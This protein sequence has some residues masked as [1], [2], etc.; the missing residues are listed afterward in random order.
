[1]V[2]QNHA[3]VERARG[4]SDSNQRQPFVSSL[5]ATRVGSAGEEAACGCG[6]TPHMPRAQIQPIMDSRVI[7]LT[8]V[9]SERISMPSPRGL[10][11]CGV[12][13]CTSMPQGVSPTVLG[14]TMEILSTPRAT[15]AVDVDRHKFMPAIHDQLRHAPPHGA[16]LTVAGVRPRAIP[17]R[18][19]LWR[20]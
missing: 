2:Q 16:G 13:M 15:S 5:Y 11:H 17:P 9:R 7:A 1:M 12:N 3:P 6:G 20:R 10:F 14:L 19:A 18:G 8:K 4:R